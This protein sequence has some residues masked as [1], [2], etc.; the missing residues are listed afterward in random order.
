MADPDTRTRNLALVVG[1]LATAG[2]ASRTE[3]SRGT[4]LARGSIR[5]LASTLIDAGVV[6]EAT[7]GGDGGGRPR[8]VLRLATDDLAIVT[9]RTDADAAVAVLH[10]ISGEELARFTARH[11]GP[12]ED[13]DTV[14]DVLAPVLDAAIGGADSRDRRIGAVS[15]IVPGVVGGDPAVVRVDHELGWRDVDVLA[16]LRERL[17][18]LS[19]LEPTLPNG[20]AL[21]G[22]GTAAARAE[23]DALDDL[24]DFLYISGHSGMGGAVVVDGEPVPGAHGSA[25]SIGH[26][27]IDPTGVPCRCGQLGCLVTIAGPEIVLDR[28]GL[29]ELRREHGLQTALEE[30]RERIAAN[31]QPAVWSWNDAVLWIG[32]ALRALDAALDPEVIVVGGYWADLVG[33]IADAVTTDGFLASDAEQAPLVLAGAAGPDAALLGGFA[34]ARSRLLADPL[35]L[36]V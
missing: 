14:L 36:A 25:G 31:D 26:V 11:G 32:R 20:L 19:E 23:L 35:H 9:A 6:R 27:A 17:P 3:L 22:E 7:V 29:T 24:G 10:G 5:T 15:V 34:T 16:G 1:R 33:D 21:L 2:P 30:L 12:L 18:R 28:A 8:T 13:P 4:G